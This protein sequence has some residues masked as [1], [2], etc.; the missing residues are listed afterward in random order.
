LGVKRDPTLRSHQKKKSG[1]R[2]GFC[3]GL[4]G[5]DSVSGKG[6]RK[7]IVRSLGMK[8]APDGIYM[9]GWLWLSDSRYLE[10]LDTK[11]TKDF[12]TGI[13]GPRAKKGKTRKRG[14]EDGE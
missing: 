10:K 5:P 2:H 7:S 6:G 4:G 9:G 11:H 14:R 1:E 13:E 3:E 12:E 8:I